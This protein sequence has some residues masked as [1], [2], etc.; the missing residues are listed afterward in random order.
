M[1]AHAEASAFAIGNVVS[2]PSHALGKTTEIHWICQ[3]RAE[4][5]LIFR[6]HDR[7]DTAT[8]S[9]RLCG[10][11]SPSE[12]LTFLS[13]GN[14][15]LVTMATNDK[16]NYPGFRA[17]V[18]QVRRGSPGK[19]GFFSEWWMKLT[20][21]LLLFTVHVWSFIQSLMC[22]CLYR[23]HMWRPAVGG[24][25]QVHFAQLPKLLPSPNKLPMVDQGELTRKTNKKNYHTKIWSLNY[26]TC[27]SLKYDWYLDGLKE[28]FHFIPIDPL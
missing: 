26:V 28:Q 9:S 5:F 10:Y 11:H 2:Q 14:V 7:L 15:M 20:P 12:P 8:F 17:Q 1:E 16:K 18:S 21:T 23:D 27:Q 3:K 25:W 19:T 4:I 24:K 13:S 6:I 22:C